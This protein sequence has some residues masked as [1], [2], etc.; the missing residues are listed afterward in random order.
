MAG[1]RRAAPP[2]GAG[3]PPE[4]VEAIVAETSQGIW[5]VDADD[6][7]TFVNARMAEMVGARPEEML[8]ASLYD[9]LDVDSGASTRIA[10]KRRRTGV[11]EYR[12]VELRTGDGSSLH[13]FVESIPLID[14]EG[15]YAGAV[16]MV[17]DI[18]RRKQIEAEI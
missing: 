4:V 10:L 13:A 2:L 5:A 7:T 14:S 11:A 1:S 8:G 15:R 18:S 6:R 3:V 9:F 16:A 17:A 12:E